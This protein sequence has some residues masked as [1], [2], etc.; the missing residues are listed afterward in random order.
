[1]MPPCSWS[2]PGRKPGT[3][4]SVTNGMLNASH[5]CT[6]RAAFSDAWMSSTPANDC[7]WFATMP[8]TCPSIRVNA[9]ITLV[10]QRSWTS[11]N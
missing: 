8:T 1:M 11:M 3:S 4:S 6:N 7:G 9:Q 2:T 5:S 10:A